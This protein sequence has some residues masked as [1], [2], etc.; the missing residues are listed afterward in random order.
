MSL[1]DFQY[2]VKLASG[3]TFHRF[4]DISYTSQC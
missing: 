4:L 1:I 3:T 2:T